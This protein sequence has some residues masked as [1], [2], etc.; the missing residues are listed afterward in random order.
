MSLAAEQYLA[1]CAAAQLGEV[2]PALE[3]SYSGGTAATVGALLVLAVQDL[4]AR[5]AREAAEAERLRSI[6]DAAVDAGIAV[7]EPRDLAGLRAG[8]ENLHGAAET[9]GEDR[10]CRRILHHYVETAEAAKLE[11]PALA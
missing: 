11:L 2:A 10:L 9:A 6:Y 5:P 7:P 4:A 1:A 3:G 8:L